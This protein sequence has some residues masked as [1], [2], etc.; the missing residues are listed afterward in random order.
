MIGTKSSREGGEGIWGKL[1]HGDP[2]PHPPGTE[3]SCAHR[4]PSAA[5][6]F[7][8]LLKG[9]C[10]HRHLLCL[11]AGQSRV[12]GV[13]TPESTLRSMSNGSW[14]MNA[15]HVRQLWGVFVQSPRA[16]SGISALFGHRGNLLMNV[17][18][19]VFLSFSVSY[20]ISLL[21]FQGVISQINDL[22]VNA[23]IWIGLQL[24][25]RESE[26]VKECLSE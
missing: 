18:S 10:D 2:R 19:L 1:Q 21:M 20:S 16:P 9:I 17:P 23:F 26:V 3:C 6:R 22:L 7:H 11:H 4:R 8:S 12:S 15:P 5:S 24:S 14:W 13:N 25:I